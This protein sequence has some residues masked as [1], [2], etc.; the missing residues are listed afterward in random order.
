MMV[1]IHARR[2]TGDGIEYCE[3]DSERV[4]IHARRVTGDKLKVKYY[5]QN[6]FQFTPVV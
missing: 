3:F 4:S 5:P 6:K 2:V 1:S